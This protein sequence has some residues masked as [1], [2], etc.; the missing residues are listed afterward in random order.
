[1]ANIDRVKKYKTKNI[2]VK[3]RRNY[4]IIAVI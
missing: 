3:K 4:T 2:K 1:M